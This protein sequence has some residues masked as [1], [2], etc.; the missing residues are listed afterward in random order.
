MTVGGVYILLSTAS[1]KHRTF[2]L[3]QKALCPY[4]SHFPPWRQSFL[5]FSLWSSFASCR[6]FTNSLIYLSVLVCVIS[7]TQFL[8]ILFV[9]TWAVCSFSLLHSVLLQNYTII[10][11]LVFSFWLLSVE[12]LCT[13]VYKFFVNMFSFL[14]RKSWEWNFGS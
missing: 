8:R 10:Y 1:V 7:F 9:V 3:H 5:I 13:F 14:F 6:N 11:L 2:P 4:P 12:L